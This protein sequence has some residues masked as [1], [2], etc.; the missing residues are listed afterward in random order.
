MVQIGHSAKQVAPDTIKHAFPQ[1]CT[2]LQIWHSHEIVD[3]CVLKTSFDKGQAQ[4]GYLYMESG[5]N[6]ILSQRLKVKAD[7]YRMTVISFFI[8]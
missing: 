8:H 5:N 6:Q 2:S 3:Q 1:F 7:C 4:V